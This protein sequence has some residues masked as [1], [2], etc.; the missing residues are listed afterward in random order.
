MSNAQTKAVQGSLID[1]GFEEVTFAEGG[2]TKLAKLTR[3]RTEIASGTY[4]VD[5][6]N[7]AEAL[8]KAAVKVKYRA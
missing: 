1:P 5:L 3:L 7:V 6:E 8:L 2:E 4:V